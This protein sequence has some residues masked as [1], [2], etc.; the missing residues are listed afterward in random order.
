MRECPKSSLCRILTSYAQILPEHC[1]ECKD[2]CEL[3]HKYKV[4]LALYAH[5]H[6]YEQ[7]CPVYEIERK[8]QLIDYRLISYWICGMYT[9]HIHLDIYFCLHRF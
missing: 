1:S 5:A 7:S 3:W 2:L 9:C 4:D 6:N 8:H